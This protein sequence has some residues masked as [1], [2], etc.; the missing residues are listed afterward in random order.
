MSFFPSLS[1][2]AP[3]IL[4]ALLVLPAI[5]FLLRVTPPLPKRVVFPPLR[6]LLGLHDEEQTP[7]GTPWWLMLLRLLAAAAIILAPSEP[8]I[9]RTLELRGTGPLVLFV[10]NGWTAAPEW[11]ARAGL[12]REAVDMAGRANRPVA[13]LATAERPQADFLDSGKADRAAL[14]LRPHPWFASRFA[15]NAAL[16]KIK[17]GAEVLWLS[18]GIDDGQARQ[19]AS[20]LSKLG[21]VRL[22]RARSGGPLAITT[23]ANTAAGFEITVVRAGT[24]GARDGMVT[25]LGEQG[26]I[27]GTAPFRFEDG[28]NKASAKI[29]IPLEMRNQA[30]RLEISGQNS[31]GA[32]AL[33]DRGAPRRAVGLVSGTPGDEP[34][35]SGSYYLERALSP[36]ADLH[37]APIADLIARNVSALILID[38]GKIAGADHDRVAK[39]VEG[40]GLLI[41]F[42]GDHTAG[43]TD[44]LVPVMLRGGGRYLGS[45]LA[46]ASPQ[47]LAEF[48]ETSPFSGLTIP[49]DVTVSRQIL[50]E[51]TVDLSTHTWARLADGT[52]MVTAAQ[53]G[54]GWIVQFHVAAGPG[55]STLPLSGLYVEMLRR[56]LALSA[57]VEPADMAANASLPPSALLDGFGKLGAPSGEAQPIRGRDIARSEPSAIHPPGLYGSAGAERALNAARGD[58]VLLPLPALGLP[59][60]YYAGRTALALQTP[61]LVLAAL[62]LLAD[63]LISLFLRGYAPNFRRLFA[64][65]AIALILLHTPAAR[66][67]D[68]AF[69]MKAALD[70]RLAYVVTGLSDVDQTSKAGLS[71]LGMA[72]AQRT[73]YAPEEP[74]GVNLEK[75]NLAFFPLLYWPMDPREKDLS[76]TALSKIAEY[77]RGG[78]TI[79]IDTRD[80]TLGPVR[81]P[82]NPGQQTLRRLLGKLD[83]PPLA[84]VPPSHVLTK[85][86]YLINSFPGRWDGGTLWAQVLPPGDAPVRGGDGVSPV[87]VGGNDWAAAWAV[88][89]RG[90][91]LVDVSPGGSTQRELSIRF[92]INLVMYAFTGNYKTDQVHVPA[93]LQRLGKGK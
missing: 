28:Q 35:L 86:F 24:A 62:L 46:W 38:V 19:T 58:T 79:L 87:I 34:L 68:D 51:P 74:L 40:G 10:D 78:G 55:W 59:A 25:A 15:A 76:P 16:A 8:Q 56:L 20:A 54:K 5:W 66:A 88:D 89:A 32:V 64:A 75:D 4:L 1:F 43:G 17:P 29:A 47:H 81:G 21:T 61:L 22:Y 60:A 37:Q 83:L 73:S 39:F 52:P 27:L 14:A 90:R 70:T 6:L 91:P 36:Y 69:D 26:Q 72:L 85:S 13:I 49:G 12:L 23:M 93:I 57:G 7:A 48:P 92:G 42:A 2:G 33:L 31:A 45:A 77:M 50:A 9:G 84:P 11:E 80:L 18:D 65:A 30:A 41:R 44:D 63:F 53:R 71:G 3:W 82:N 67:G